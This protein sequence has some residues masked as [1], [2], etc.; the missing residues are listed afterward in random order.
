ME[1]S[2]TNSVDT[3]SSNEQENVPI[4]ALVLSKVEKLFENDYE[5]ADEIAESLELAVYNH[6]IEIALEPSWEDEQFVACYKNTAFRVFSN[7][8]DNINSPLV[9]DMIDNGEIDPDE[10]VTINPEKLDP[11]RW[12]KAKR[13]VIDKVMFEKPDP[14][15][16]HDGEFT[17]PKCGSKKTTYY[18]LQTRSSDENMTVFVIDHVCGYRWRFG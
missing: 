8:T 15:K 17:C 10:I 2:S 7:L 1:M 13:T 9:W 14:E 16:M 4:R 12:E 5:G 18:Q 6:A 3:Q 11:E